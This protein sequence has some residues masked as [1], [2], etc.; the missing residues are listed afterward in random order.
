VTQRNDPIFVVGAGRS[1]TT[2]LQALIGSHPRIA[3]PPETHFLR[4]MMI[5]ASSWGDLHDDSKLR[6]AVTYAVAAPALQANGFD[7]DRIL[8]RAKRGPR[9]LAGVL[10]AMMSDFAERQG[11]V[12][13]SEKSPMQ[14]SWLIWEELP[15]AQVVH[16]VRDPIETIAS[17][18]TKTGIDMHPTIAAQTWRR[19]TTNSI[20][21]GE[22]RG[23][24]YYLR[25]RYEDLAREPE[26][27]MAKVFAF[28]HED[29]DPGF[30]A[31]HDRRLA[32]LGTTSSP[33]TKQVLQPIRIGAPIAEEL[34]PDKAIAQITAAVADMMPA[35]GYPSP[36]PEVVRAGRRAN[37][38]VGPWLRIRFA[39]GR[40]RVLHGR[41]RQEANERRRAERLR[42]RQEKAALRRGTGGS[43]S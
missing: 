27:V 25:I 20:T 13:W 30:I 21:A 3:A 43:A 37:A 31:D 16:I 7:A 39:V 26:A 14:P 1:G 40:W 2:L 28:L 34:L 18:L 33:L 42:R 36:P 10:D 17:N 32:T 24:D 15:E 12:R 11:K 9:T 8:E 5:G 41:N 35:L 38:V 23:P 29:F 22:K 4:R 19:F 6:A